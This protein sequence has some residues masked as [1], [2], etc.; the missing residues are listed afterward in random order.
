MA[1]AKY[2][3]RETKLAYVEQIVSG[4][5]TVTEA[6]RDLDCARSTIY[7]WLRKFSV[8]GS[9]SFPGSGKMKA[10]VEYVRNL[11]KEN[12]QLKNEV[13]FLKKAAAYFAE[14]QKKSTR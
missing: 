1:T 13:E 9:S 12:R 7:S 10:E 6:M 5:L 11:E 2:Y 3:D 8:D 14:D 4:K